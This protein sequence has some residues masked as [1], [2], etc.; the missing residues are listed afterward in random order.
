MI[1]LATRDDVPAIAAIYD[2]IHTNEEAGLTT[3]GWIRSIY[4]TRESA[5]ASIAKVDMFVLEE[6]GTVVA[7]AKINQEQ[8]PEYADAH[9]EHP[10]PDEKIMVL[11]TLVVSPS[12]KGKGLGTRFVDF[13]EAYALEQGRP[14]LRMDTNERN[15]AARA[16]YRKLGYTEVS[17]V[18]CEFN[19]IPG[20]RLVC[21]E[22]KL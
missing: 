17:I 12:V 16:L 3:I 10:A 22:K 7:A 9:W 14:F 4:P 20:V 15:L 6:N 21:L 1:R 13:Y 5:A 11:H 18:P 8:V 19:G 2:T